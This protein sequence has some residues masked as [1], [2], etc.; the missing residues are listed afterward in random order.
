VP[1]KKGDGRRRGAPPIFLPVSLARRRLREDVVERQA[2]AT[3][4]RVSINA[5][6]RAYQLTT[7]QTA[8]SF[9][10]AWCCAADFFT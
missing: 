1:A 5:L 2:A 3:A 10:I 6:L 9:D 8:L 4:M 7:G